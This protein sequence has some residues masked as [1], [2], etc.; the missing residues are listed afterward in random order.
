MLNPGS[1]APAVTG[2]GTGCQGWPWLTAQLGSTGLQGGCT[3]DAPLS[4]LAFLKIPWGQQSSA[5]TFSPY[6]TLSSPV[7]PPYTSSSAPRLGHCTTSVHL[8][9]GAS[10]SLPTPVPTLQSD[11]EMIEKGNAE[12]GWLPH[13][14]VTVLIH[15]TGLHSP[16]LPEEG[17]TTPVAPITGKRLKFWKRDSCNPVSRQDFSPFFWM[18]LHTCW[19]KGF[20]AL[21]RKSHLALSSP[22]NGADLLP[23]LSLQTAHYFQQQ[24]QG[25]SEQEN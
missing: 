14:G 22:G 3:N 5:V 19:E 25:V 9:P 18:R 8:P 20:S 13:L 7:H 1:T 12:A 15:N 4:N 10:S 2:A 6:S 23:A 21:P 16:R 11:S 17:L 24:Q